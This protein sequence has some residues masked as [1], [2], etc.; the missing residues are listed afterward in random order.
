MTTT[1]QVC[2]RWRGR[3]NAAILLAAA[4]TAVGMGVTPAP[5]HAADQYIAL[6]LGYVNENPPVTMAGGS[7]IAA[8][9]DAAAQGA[10][11]NCVNNGGGHCV[12]VVIGTNECAAAASNDYGE[13]VGA[14]GASVAAASSSAKALL[15]N[16]TGAK[17]IV[18]GCA[19][20]STPPP[21]NDPPPPPAPKQGPTVSFNTVL[22]GLEA[23]IT[24]RSGVSSQCT[25]A[26]DNYN[27]SFALPANSKYDLRIVPA[28]PRF[29]NWTITITCD[30]GTSTT[31]TTYF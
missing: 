26:T 5:A 3:T 12:T 30:N 23:H 7:A 27:R 16:Q 25:Y 6:A 17:V 21:P 15:Q 9:Q 14:K 29:R 22:G 1:N 11:T 8:T 31:A 28:V 4:A 2:T 10:L 20:G 18:S 24:D 19:N 13:E